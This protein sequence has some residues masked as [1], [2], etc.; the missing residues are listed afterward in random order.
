MNF[1]IRFQMRFLHLL[2]PTHP[3][4]HAGLCL[5]VSVH[6]MQSCLF[7]LNTMRTDKPQNALIAFYSGSPFTLC[8][9]YALFALRAVQSVECFDAFDCLV[10]KPM[11]C[12]GNRRLISAL[13]QISSKMKNYVR[14]FHLA[15]R[16][17]AKTSK[18]RCSNSF[19]LF[20]AS[21]LFV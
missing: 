17:R 1:Q 9:S 12:H 3:K 14:L 21:S 18:Q 13:D 8:S 19:Y 2:L 16:K 4:H 10:A 5:A 6:C 7:A 20:T 11:L 15:L